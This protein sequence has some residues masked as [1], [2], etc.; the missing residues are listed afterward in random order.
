MSFD[1]LF[2]LAGLYVVPFW[3][4]MA[5]FPKWK[6]TKSV[7]NSYLP[8]MPLGFLYIYFFVASFSIESA[9]TL[10]NPQLADFTQILSQEGPAS[11]SW[12][13]ILFMDLFVGRWMYWQG[14]EKN[15]LTTHSLILCL[16]F[17]PVGL[18]SHI[19]TAA[20]FGNKKSDD[21]DA[22]DLEEE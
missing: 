19:A 15:I 20:L 14:Q 12:V 6:I 9:L 17:G 4:A 11:A 3:I 8:F 1:L 2:G 21:L 5:I 16:F 7:M 22:K 13:H 18:L 10:A